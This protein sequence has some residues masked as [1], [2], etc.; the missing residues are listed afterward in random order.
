MPRSGR[1]PAR[2]LFFA[3]VLVGAAAWVPPHVHQGVNAG[4]GQQLS[5]LPAVQAAMPDREQHAGDFGAGYRTTPSRWRVV[6]G[7]AAER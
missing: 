6:I 5:K 1:Q 7:R 4:A 2:Q 3:S